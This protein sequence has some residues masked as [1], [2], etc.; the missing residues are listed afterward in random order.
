MPPI[1]RADLFFDLWGLISSSFHSDLIIMLNIIIV[2][3]IELN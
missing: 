1:L 3:I 2:N